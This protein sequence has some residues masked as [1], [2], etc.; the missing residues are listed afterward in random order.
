MTNLLGLHGVSRSG[1]DT[2]AGILVELYGYEQKVLAAPLRAIL[3]QINPMVVDINNDRVTD[4]YHL[5]GLVDQFG[6]DKVKETWPETVEWMIRLGQAGRDLIEEDI[7]LR[8]VMKNLKAR[9]VISDVRQPNEV[10]A[11]RKMGGQL[12]RI[13]RPGVS[14]RGMDSLL[15][16]QEFDAVIYNNGSLLDLEDAVRHAYEGT[17]GLEAD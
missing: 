13:V 5:A 14:A 11:I 2:V 10:A 17:V 9:T 15:D 7:W 12:W 4:G 16:D 1:K 6:W 3:L 8:P